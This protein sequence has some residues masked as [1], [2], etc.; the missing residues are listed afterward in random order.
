MTRRE[1]ARS[2]YDAQGGAY[3]MFDNKRKEAASWAERS[4]SPETIAPF[5]R[6]QRRT[7]AQPTSQVG[8]TVRSHHSRRRPGVFPSSGPQESHRQ[9]SCSDNA[10]AA[11][12]APADPHSLFELALESED[13][14][15][16]GGEVGHGQARDEWLGTESLTVSRRVI[17]PPS[18][19]CELYRRLHRRS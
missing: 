6:R 2:G 11:G 1:A 13:R 15:A 18:I 3:S 5:G 12:E 8:R 7:P 4:T 14:A 19:A 16:N 17:R 10:R 9:G